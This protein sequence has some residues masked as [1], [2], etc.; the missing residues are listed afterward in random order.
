MHFASSDLCGQAAVL[1]AA[2]GKIEQDDPACVLADAIFDGMT[3][4]KQ[5][6]R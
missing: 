3:A 5:V 1:A 4:G 6:S 2:A